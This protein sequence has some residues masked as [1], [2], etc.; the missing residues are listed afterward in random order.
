M[1]TR[2]IITNIRFVII[3]SVIFF[4]KQISRKSLVGQCL[5]L[6]AFMPGPG[7]QSR[8]GELRSHKL[9]SMTP[10]KMF[11]LTNTEITFIVINNSIDLRKLL[12]ANNSNTLKHFPTNITMFI[13]IKVLLFIMP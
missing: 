13:A 12:L 11:Q 2:N 3:R 6:G 7:V 5:R 9:C 8:V 10:S 4:K 1:F